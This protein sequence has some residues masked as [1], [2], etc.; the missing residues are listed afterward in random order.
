MWVSRPG[1]RSARSPRSWSGQRR[2]SCV[3][4][5]ETRSAT[6]G[7]GSGTGSGRR[8][9]AAGMP[10][11][12]IALP[13]RRR[14]PRS[15][16]AARNRAGW[17]LMRSCA[18]RCR[19]GCWTSTAPNRSLSGC[20]WIFPRM[21]RCGCPTKPSI[22]RSMCR[23]AAICAAN[24]INVCAPGARCADPNAAP[25]SA[26][27]ASATWSISASAHPGSRT[28]RCPGTGRGI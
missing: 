20:R 14:A 1:S 17:R 10:S 15:G 19:L 11:R 9:K 6:G 4:S 26:A 12:G 2:P 28:A 23:A 25:M 18:M 16:R 3:K 5:S 21:R 8:R 22:S 24:C 27:A 13:V 7:I